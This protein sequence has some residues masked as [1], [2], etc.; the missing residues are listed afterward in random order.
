MGTKYYLSNM[1]E[2]LQNY[3]E[4]GPGYQLLKFPISEENVGCCPILKE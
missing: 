4:K 1:L 3:L 2:K